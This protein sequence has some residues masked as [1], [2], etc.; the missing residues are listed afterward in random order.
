MNLQR[1]GKIGQKYVIGID[2]G[3]TSTKAALYEVEAEGMGPLVREK[4]TGSSNLNSNSPEQVRQNLAE[5]RELWAGLDVVAIGIGVAGIST[6]GAAARIKTMLRDLEISDRIVVVGDQEAALRGAFGRHAGI[7]LISGT[8]SIA[9]GQDDR[10][11]LLRAGGYGHLIDD[12]G[13]AYS[14]GRA[15]LAAYVQAYDGRIERTALIDRLEKQLGE[16]PDKALARAMQLAYEQPFDKARIAA[17]AALLD[18]AL[19]ASDPLALGIAA[20]AVDQLMQLVET[21]AKQMPSG[22]IPLVMTGGMLAN[23]EGYRG[24]LVERLQ[25]SSFNYDISEPRADARRGAADYAL[26]IYRETAD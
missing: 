1:V 12:E 16:T 18:P 13:S 15:L 22:P 14:I 9:Y 21:V 2:G 6:P 17:R 3:G 24:L 8:G 19:Q 20:Q 23:N 11:R 7:L 25:A 26:A 5:L 4:T 10:G